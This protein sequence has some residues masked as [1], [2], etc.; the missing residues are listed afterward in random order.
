MFV[1]FTSFVF[2]HENIIF[3]QCI[4]FCECSPV[5][6]FSSPCVCVCVCVCLYV[7]VCVC[8]RESE[9]VMMG[10]CVSVCMHAHTSHCVS[11]YR[12]HFSLGKEK[13]M[14]VALSQVCGS[15]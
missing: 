2:I 1:T 12:S 14:V 11:V 7:C 3:A 5:S 6:I 13:N 8:V 9:C 15:I 4:F 10:E